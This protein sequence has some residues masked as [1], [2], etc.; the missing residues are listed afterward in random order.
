MEPLDE[1]LA[2]KTIEKP[3]F[4]QIHMEAV[5]KGLDYYREELEDPTLYESVYD[6]DIRLC[7]EIAEDIKIKLVQEESQA[8][9]Q[10]M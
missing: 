3:D 9:G 4:H 6:Y 1:L 2:G 8:L 10:T 7:T 5:I